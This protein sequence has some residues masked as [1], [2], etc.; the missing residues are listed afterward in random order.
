MITIEY[1]IFTANVITLNAKRL[2]TNHYRN[3]SDEDL[4]HR[5]ASKQDQEAFGT[6]YQR[7][8]HLALGTCIKYLKA[9]EPAKDAVQVIFTK[10]WT[11]VHQYQVRRFKPWFYQ[12]I[13][14]HCLMELRK[15]DPN[16]KTV[17]EWDMDIVEFEETLHHKVNEEQLL[18]YL[19]MC[20][21]GLNEEQRSCITRFYLDQKSYNETA[22]LTGYSDKQVK[23]HIQ[24]GRR[25][26]KNC[27]QQKI[28]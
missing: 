27:L 19:N 10:L 15:N 3:L 26:L 20:L 16:R 13:K 7:Y 11:D 28:S 6:L 4:V 1:P 24:N 23:S 12:V 5:I 25:N 21:K 17:A 9:A 22:T 2:S 18:L 8:V 14:N